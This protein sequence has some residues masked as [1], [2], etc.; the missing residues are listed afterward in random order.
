[1]TEVCRVCK[2]QFTKKADFD[3]L[4]PYIPSVCS[5]S[6]FVAYLQEYPEC[7]RMVTAKYTHNKRSKVTRSLAE[8]KVLAWFDMWEIDA[9]YEP[10]YI[11][12]DSVRKKYMP[13]IYLPEYDLFVEVKNGLLEPTAFTKIVAAS[14][15]VNLIVIDGHCITRIGCNKAYSESQR[16][17]NRKEGGGWEQNRTIKS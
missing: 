2:K 7:G 9:S 6:C 10:Y 13:D 3:K 12:L 14:Q 17:Y 11:Q 8:D 15:R 1:M 5:D 16:Q 4:L